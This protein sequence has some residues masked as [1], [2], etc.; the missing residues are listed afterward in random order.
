M[1]I[2]VSSLCLSIVLLPELLQLLLILPVAPGLLLLLLLHRLAGCPVGLA[3]SSQG[4][5]FP[6]F[7][8]SSFSAFLA[9]IALSVAVGDLNGKNEN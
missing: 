4:L 7:P 6:V 9:C 1:R 5:L 8:N 2:L 3:F